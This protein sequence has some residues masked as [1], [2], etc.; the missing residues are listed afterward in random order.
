MT[1]NAVLCAS[2]AIPTTGDVHAVS[3]HELPAPT[4]ATRLSELEKIL[5]LTT[6]FK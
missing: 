4:V 1:D 5:P 3:H 2:E 6:L